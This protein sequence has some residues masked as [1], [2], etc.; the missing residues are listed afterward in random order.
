MAGVMTNVAG[1]RGKENNS[2]IVNGQ[3]HLPNIHCFSVND[4]ELG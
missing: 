1:V 4:T 2:Q 3:M